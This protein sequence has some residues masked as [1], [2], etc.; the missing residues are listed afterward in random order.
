[1]SP[2]PLFPAGPPG[3]VAL[4]SVVGQLLVFVFVG[5]VAVALYRRFVADE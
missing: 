1:M 2:P 4:A 3:G 5:L